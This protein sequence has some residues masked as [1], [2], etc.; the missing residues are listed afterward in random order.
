M[1]MED[2]QWLIDLQR[3]EKWWIENN[4][5]ISLDEAALRLKAKTDPDQN[6]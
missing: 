1:N 2:V 3:M 4:D 6:K 5:W